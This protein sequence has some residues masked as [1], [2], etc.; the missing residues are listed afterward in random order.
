MVAR[1]TGAVGLLVVLVSA[2]GALAQTGRVAGDIVDETGGALPGATVTLSGS[3]PAR[4]LQTDGSGAFILEGLADGT[5]TVTVSL[6][7]FAPETRELVVAGDPLDLGRITLRIAGF[8]DAVVVTA[9]R[10]EV[11]VIDAPVTTSVISAATL[12]ASPATNYGDVLRTVPGVNVVQLSARD[13][14]VTSR[15]ATGAVANSQLVL[16]DGRSVYLDFFGLVLWDLLPANMEDVEQIEVVRGPA[17]ATWGANAMTGAINLITKSPRE[18]VGTTVTLTGGVIDREAGSTIGR[19]PGTLFGANATVTRAP[20]DR[21]AYR[22]SAGYFTSDAFAR[23]TGRIPVIF[24]PREPGRLVGG[25]A[26]PIDATGAFGAAFANRGTSQPKFDVRVD[27]ELANGRLTYAAGVA[28]T[29]GLVHSGVG[30][31]DIQPGSFLGYGKVNY[32]RGNLRAQVFANF[33]QGDAPNLLLPDPA[34]GR[35]VQLGFRTQ[36]YDA[37]LGHSTF[38]GDRHLLTYG[39]NVRQNNFDITIAPLSEDRLEAGVYLQD[40]IFLDPFRLVLG[41]RVDKFGNLGTPTFSP[42]LAFIIKPSADQSLT[43]SYNRAFRAPSTINNFLEMSIVNPVN[44][45]G[46]AGFLP[47]T[48]RPVIGP[49]LAQ[50]FPL[51]VRATGSDTPFGSAE[52]VPLL[53]ESLTAYEVSYTGTF[54][55][56]ATVGGAVYLN[57]RDDPIN[58]V[59]LPPQVDPYTAQN[60]P[61]GWAAYLGADLLPAPLASQVPGLLLQQMAQFGIYLPR[62]AFTYVNLG[63]TR[64][65]GAEVWWDQRFSRSASAWV[66]YSWQAEPEILDAPNPYLPEEL[67]LPPAHRGNAGFS[68]NGSRYIGSVSVSAASDA[69]WSDVLTREYHGY[70]SGYTMVNGSIGVRWQDGAVTTVL[71]GTNLLN[72]HIKQHIFGDILRRT[73]LAEVRFRL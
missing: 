50:P 10:S 42:R 70:S 68:W 24:D 54:W 60:L 40:E 3:G 69:F 37:E 36:T 32:T 58:F 51:V 48:L 53:Q 64:Q 23:P 62:T 44:L 1:C 59:G 18:S 61:P 71:K 55:R 11:R 72:R 2:S 56:G 34:T 4:V 21:L 12:E 67:S 13:V 25:A 39:G 41:G 20:T 33:L 27:Q 73:V 49:R 45:S 22:I 6:A 9:S 57:Q 38:L 52:R 7:G 14:N 47:P 5:Y 26:Y 16:M 19:G 35:P 66:N 46:L 63:P 29:E 31:F 28:G 43:L 30:P 17:S 8:G 65:V 15:Q